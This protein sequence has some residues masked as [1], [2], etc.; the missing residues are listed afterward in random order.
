MSWIGAIIIA[1][2]GT[3]AGLIKARTLTRLDFLYSE[4]T[5]ALGVM[6]SEIS[7]RAA[8]MD[9]II[10]VISAGQAEY[11]D[12]FTSLL[13]DGL[14]HLGENSFCSIWDNAVTVGL[15]GISAR[16]EFALHSLGGTLGRYEAAEQCAAIDRCTAVISAEQ[17][18]LQSGLNSNKRMYIG[19]GAALGLTV[20]I[21]LI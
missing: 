14:A 18:Q 12:Q 13:K 21:M 19:I 4:L 20:A 11:I 7:S 5:A 3:A 9:E 2:A 10:G 15:R 8:P 16:C 6:K 17:H 1:F